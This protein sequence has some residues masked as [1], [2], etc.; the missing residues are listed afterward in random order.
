MHTLIVTVMAVA[1]LSVTLPVILELA[2]LTAAF[3]LC[4]RRIQVAATCTDLRLSVVIPAYNEELLVGRTIES[5]NASIAASRNPG[6]TRI[7]AIAHNCS[8]RTAERAASAGAEVLVLNDPH[9]RG[10]GFALRRGFDQV[11][12]DGADAALV[13]DADSTVSTRLIDEVR[14]A[15]QSGAEAV[16]C[17]YEMARSVESA[18]GQLNALALRA[19]NLIRPAGRSRLGFSAGILGNGFAV[20]KQVFLRTP[21]QALSL[22]EDLEY[23]IHLVEGGT[24]VVFLEDAQVFSDLP[25]SDAGN[26]TQRSRW[27]GGR[28][29]AARRWVGPLV[30]RVICG[31]FRSIEPLLDVAGLPLAYTAALLLLGLGLPV[32]WLRF[33]A[34][35]ALGVMAMHVIAA[36]GAG[37]RFW[38]DVRVLCAVP[39]YILWKLRLAPSLLRG[40]SSN[41]AWIRTERATAGRKI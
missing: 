18:K 10:K 15:L 27:E 2:L 1:I 34:G 35:A 21:Y 24:R 9:A 20:S 28:F 17:R 31:H 39:F 30:R 22:V 5:L 37:E 8:D 6:A 16:Q 4:K 32:E 13:I 11:F 38:D 29:Q 36:A 23:H 25:A 19:F 14:D 26:N 33:Y 3:L 40:A 41:A 7:V 12:S